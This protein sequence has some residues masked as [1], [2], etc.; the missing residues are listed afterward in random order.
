[1]RIVS[2]LAGAVEVEQGSVVAECVVRLANGREI[3]VPIRAGMDTAEW[4]WDRPDVRPSVKHRKAADL[5]ELP[6]A[7]GV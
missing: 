1:M 6:G 2:F 4:A 7:R 5:R 3:W